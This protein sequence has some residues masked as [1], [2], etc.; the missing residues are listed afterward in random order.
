MRTLLLSVGVAAL[1]AI[2]AFPHHET[3]SI[4]TNGQGSLFFA[5]GTAIS[6]VAVHETALPFR[7]APFGG[8]STYLRMVNEG[9]VAFGLANAGEAHFA[10]TGTEIFDGRPNENLRMVGALYH[11]NGQ[12]AV[13]NDSSL[14]SIADLAGKRIPTD[15]AS[16]VIFKFIT[17]SLLATEGL[18][19]RDVKAF[20]V[21]NFVQGINALI[22][23]HV[24]AAYIDV[25]SGIGAKANAEIRGGWR[26]LTFENTPA[27]AAAMQRV[28]PFGSPQVLLPSEQLLGVVEPTSM[29]RVVAYLLAGTHVSDDV[30]YELTKTI[31][32][33]KQTLGDAFGKFRDFDPE[34]MAT[35]HSVPYHA[36]AIRY[37]E[38]VGQWPPES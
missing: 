14:T 30:V 18:S 16:G 4:G 10:F 26:F 35:K 12:F 27:A 22:A 23:G 1:L 36:G 34:N 8:S 11:M 32:T 31:H 33:N 38:E 6:A 37:F 25:G 28:F 20:P 5:T 29:F 7:V 2:S 24:D 17:G 21:S 13:P 3:F 19:F 15:F 9:E